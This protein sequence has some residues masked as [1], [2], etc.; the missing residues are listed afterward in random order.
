MGRTNLYYEFLIGLIRV[1]QLVD[2]FSN[3]VRSK[4][5]LEFFCKKSNSHVIIIT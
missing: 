1:D 3:I 2:P 4:K 5:D